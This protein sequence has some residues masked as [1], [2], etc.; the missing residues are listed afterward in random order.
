LL[1]RPEGARAVREVVEKY[2]ADGGTV[3][4]DLAYYAASR[5]LA[6]KVADTPGVRVVATSAVTAGL[7]KEDVLPSSGKGKL[8]V[9][10]G[11]AGGGATVLCVA[12][13]GGEP[14]VVEEKVGKGRI[15]A[16]DLQTLPE[17]YIWDAGSFHKYLFVANALGNPVRYG[18]MYARRPTYDQVVELMRDLVKA[19][20]SLRM[21]E[22]GPAA[23]GLKIYSLSA[24][25]A[26]APGL[27][28]TAVVHGNEWENALGLVRFARL[29]AED[30]NG[31]GA[32]LARMRVTLIPVM[33]PSGYAKNTRQNGRGVDI[34]RNGDL[35]WDKIKGQE[36]PA[37]QK[38]GPG[39]YDWKG[40][41]PLSEP[42]LQTFRAI[43]EAGNYVAFLDVHGNPS[44]TGYNKSLDYSAAGKPDSKEKAQ[45][46]RDL[47]NAAVG[48]RF[49]LRQQHE[50]DVRPL[51]V[52]S[53][54]AD[55]GMGRVMTCSFAARGKYG[56]LVELPAGIYTGD[57][58]RSA[59]GTLVSTDL[60]TE[61]CIAF[62]RSFAG[63]GAAGR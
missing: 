37:G 62:V 25:K 20:P 16:A 45:G 63:E 46:M 53:F 57:A 51:M 34:N 15:V 8:C 12:Q 22:E 14:A 44:G 26:D 28:I 9:L 43:C 59:Y 29:L 3:F 58:E 54:A 2:A 30:A 31:A 50:K 10:A 40:E 56:V 1:Q 36:T 23:D 35:D 38:Y 32:D 49:V 24:G 42:E 60:V 55:S 21:K 11:P 48:G 19:H 27:L 39:A 4:A 7:H 41:S 13:A 5:G 47:F 61:L 33:N 17:P 18:E 52:D 6:T